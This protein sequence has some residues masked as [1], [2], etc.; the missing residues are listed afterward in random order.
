MNKKRISSFIRDGEL[1]FP[2]P[3]TLYSIDSI[4]SLSFC[5]SYLRINH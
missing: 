5:W 1:H 3:F 2:S 4:D